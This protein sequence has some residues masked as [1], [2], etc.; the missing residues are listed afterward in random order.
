M[1]KFLILGNMNLTT[2]T[3]NL[4]LK[5]KMWCGTKYNGSNMIKFIYYGKE[6]NVPSLFWTNLDYDFEK[7][8]VELTKTYNP[9]DYPKYDNYDAIEVSR[10]KNI[11]MDYTGLMGVPLSF[12]YKLNP[13]QFELIDIKSCS[14]LLKLSGKTLYARLI[15]KN[16]H[17]V[18][19]E[20][21]VKKNFNKISKPPL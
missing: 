12:I 1:K 6:V 14:K 9:I 17:P 15:I 2:D 4:L 5:E 7:P 13:N 19:T 8:F 11:P 16:K 10:S 18:A 21:N 3:S 20:N